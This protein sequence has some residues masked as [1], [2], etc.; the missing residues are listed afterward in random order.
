MSARA[1][2]VGGPFDGVGRSFDSDTVATGGR[3]RGDFAWIDG[4]G[5]V[6]RGPAPGR[7]LYRLELAFGRP[8]FFAFAGDQWERCPGGC[9]GYTRKVEGGRERQ[10]CLG[11]GARGGGRSYG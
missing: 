4:T 11:C 9:G 6:W 10:P 2:V 8:V 7:E 3:R 5:R 1:Q